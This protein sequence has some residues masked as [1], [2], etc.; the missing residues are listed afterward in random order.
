M[1]TGSVCAPMIASMR[2]IPDSGVCPF[3]KLSVQSLSHVQLF[4]TPRTAAREASLS[5]TNTQSFLKLVSIELVTPSNHL[6]LCCPFLL[7]S[8]MF[9][10]IRVFSNESV[11]HIR[12]QKCWS[13]SFSI[14]LSSEYSGLISSKIHWLDLTVQGTLKRLLQH[15]TSKA[16]VLRH[17]AFYKET[18]TSIHDC[19]KNPQIRDEKQ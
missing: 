2:K 8:S 1:L 7:P 16:S 13:F 3:L 14:S 10:S 19:L 5:I 12:W 9:P 18:L 6:I 11:L 17:S 4:V 15:C